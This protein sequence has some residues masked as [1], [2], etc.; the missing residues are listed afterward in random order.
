MS[1]NANPGEFMLELTD[2]RKTFDGINFPLRGVSLGVRPGGIHAL[3]GANGAGKSVLLKLINGTYRR[4]SGSIRW[5]GAEVHWSTP[6]D[7][8]K[9]GI[10]TVP[11]HAQLAPTMSVLDNVFMG[12]ET[13]RWKTAKLRAELA[14]LM[15]QIGYELDPD[16]TVSELS[17]GEGQMVSLMQALAR[18]GSLL[19]LDEPTA[20]LTRHERE[21]VFSAV[22][23]LAAQGIGFIYVSHFLDEILDLSDEVTVLRNGEVTLDGPLS[24]Q[25]GTSLVQAMLGRELAALESE[26][27]PV[28][29]DAATVLKV[30]DLRPLGSLGPFSFEVRAGEILG[31]AGLLGSGRTELLSAIY[32]EDKKAL[33]HVEINGVET[34]RRGPAAAVKAG[35]AL[36]PEDR[37]RSG[38]IGDWSIT[39]NA[40]LAY[41]PIGAWHRVLPHQ[42]DERRRATEARAA[43]GIRC[44]SIDQ[45]V[46]ELSG[47]NAQKVVFSK[48]VPGPAKLLMLDDPTVG[49]DVGAKADLLSLVR[50]FARDGKAVI[51]VSS[52]FEELLAVCHRI[53]VIAKGRF[54]TELTT[55]ATTLNEVTAIASGT[56][57]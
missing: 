54:V 21:V 4:T 31:I 13:K 55:A 2:V 18:G 16:T 52:E 36:V 45:P 35:M 38:L 30:T 53:L 14:A 17:V 9:S 6:G 29:H 1:E 37:V 49:I 3:I 34:V 24:G 43:L 15:D 10:A 5:R 27:L 12:R 39:G 23:T 20:S 7:A 26:A 44:A 48:W 19:M 22:R 47:G 33:G 57:A 40:S 11:Q 56:A 32:G 8:L 51:V 28:T 41:L 25:T 46:N 50:S 42:A